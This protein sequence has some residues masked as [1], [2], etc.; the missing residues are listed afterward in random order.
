MDTTV[1]FKR[2]LVGILFGVIMGVFC[3]SGAFAAGFLQFSAVNLA[4]VL[5][6][7]GIMGFVIAISALRIAW[8]WNGILVGL[9][10]GSIFSYSLFMNMGPV[11]VPFGNALVN[12]IFGLII[13]F[14]TTVVFKLPSPA[15]PAK[16]RSVRIE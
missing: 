16:N 7:R 1:S 5:L 2:I 6:N 15:A 11:F 14:F 3:A 4:W 8:Y 12:G 13:E 9:V 10:V